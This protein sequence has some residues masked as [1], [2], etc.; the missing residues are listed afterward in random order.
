M[1]KCIG[2]FLV[3]LFLGVGGLLKAQKGCAYVIMLKITLVLVKI[4]VL[5]GKKV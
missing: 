5:V 4:Y 2:W 1:E 3:Y